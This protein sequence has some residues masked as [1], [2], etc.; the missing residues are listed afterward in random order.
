MTTR[1]LPGRKSPGLLGVL[2]ALVAAGSEAPAASAVQDTVDMPARGW[3]GI[4]PTA[5]ALERSFRLVVVDVYRNSPAD[6]E[7][8]VPGD[9]LIAVDGNPLTT[10]QTWFR[11]T[12]NMHAGQSIRVVVA[13]NGDQYEVN[14]V[15]DP[16]PEFVG[17]DPLYELEAAR[18]RFDSLTGGFLDF[19][20]AD[21]PWPWQTLPGIAFRGEFGSEAG[22]LTV[23]FGDS[24]I[25]AGSVLQ[26]NEDGN[27]LT[28]T[29]R[30]E[31]RTDVES[32]PAAGGGRHGIAQ[33][34]RRGG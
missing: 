31:D 20:P 23:T 4:L 12:S 32:P 17:P 2:A 21:E 18:A 34:P 10:Y 11:S 30:G 25:I 7:G 13:R 15:A 24:G 9:W 27:D 28:V 5:P 19:P 22:P 14:L 26:S 1:A 6:L 3:I 16:A 33:S 29:L 8:I